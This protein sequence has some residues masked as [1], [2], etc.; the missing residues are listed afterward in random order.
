MKI[1]NV[2]VDNITDS[3]GKITDAWSSFFQNLI[4]QMTL[5]LSDEGYRVP[6]L[7]D[8]QITQLNTAKS[9]NTIVYNTTTQRMM[10]NNSGTYENIQV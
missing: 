10:I 7:T 9:E 5:N 4:T 8:D 3:E 2:P 1:P 6:Y